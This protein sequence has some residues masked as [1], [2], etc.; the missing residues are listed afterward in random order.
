MSIGND[1]LAI[2]K[3]VATNHGNDIGFGFNQFVFQKPYGCY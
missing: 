2:E 3:Y 1:D